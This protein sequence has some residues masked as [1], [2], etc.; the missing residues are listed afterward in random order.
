MISRKGKNH[1]LNQQTL[2]YTRLSKSHNRVSHASDI[3][4]P[5]R[6]GANDL[7]TSVVVPYMEDSIV[8]KFPPVSKR[9]ISNVA[10]KNFADILGKVNNGHLLRLAMDINEHLDVK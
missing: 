9:K 5:I 2:A 8:C 10:L 1:K 6:W 4:K 3:S 7:E